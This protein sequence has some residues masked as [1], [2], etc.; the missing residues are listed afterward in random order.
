MN[1]KKQLS[2]FGTEFPLA[3]GGSLQ[4][5]QLRYETYG[6]LNSDLSNV[7][8]ILHA[9]TGWPAAHEW[10]H[11]LVGKGR[12]IDPEQYFIICPNF[13]GSCY[14]STGPESINPST[15]VPY[16]ASFPTISTRDIAKA[17]LQLLDQLGIAGVALGIGG[18]MGGMVLLEMA[19]LDPNRFRAIIPIAVS[20]EHSAWR[21]SFSS[22]IRNA[23]TAADPSLA[24][25][26]KLSAGLHL[27]RQFATISYRCSQEFDSRFA[28]HESE[29]IFEIENYLRHQ[30][31]K[32]VE[33]FSPYSYLT[34]TK[35]MELYELRN[36]EAITCPSLIVGIASDI[37]YQPAEIERFAARLP[38]GQY[39]TLDADHGH[40]SFLVD[41]DTLAQIIEPFINSV[42]VESTLEEFTIA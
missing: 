4:T 18:S 34:L 8:L 40:D 38:Q 39:V 2:I 16:R 12:L 9:L 10:W 33:R 19:A 28:R 32:I 7:V 25:T 23:I 31:E 24:D 35:A 42:I 36:A 30:G 11:G 37:L 13:L 20:G 14:G 41:A 6:T 22:T 5:F 21:I 3:H 26:D 15:G 29:G 17:N 1:H 27:A